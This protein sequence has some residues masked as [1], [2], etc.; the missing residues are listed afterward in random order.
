MGE[1]K[2]MYF[3]TPTFRPVGGVVKIFDYVNHAIALGYEPIVACPEPYK[4]TLPL[5]RIER[6]KGI[7][8]ENG[9]RF[10]DLDK[11]SV[12]PHDLAF[13]S[14]PTH[15]EIVEPRLSRW[16]RHEQVIFIVQNVRWANPRWIGGYAVRLLS[17]PMARIMTNDVVLDAVKPYLNPSS[18]SEVILLGNESEFFAKE[19]QSGFGEPLKV[20]YTTW[21]SG[22]G[23]EVASLLA[24]DRG[25]EFR[26]I[27]DPVGWDELRDLYQWSDVFLA[28]PLAEEGFYMPGLEAMA[29]GAVVVSPDA[30]GNRA[31]CRFGENCV[32]VEF[33]DAKGYVRALRDLK[34]AGAGEID[35]LRREGRETAGLHTLE[36]EKERFGEFMERLIGRLDRLGPG[37]RRLDARSGGRRERP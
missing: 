31:Y 5:F 22:V 2:R 24:D 21:K 36:H 33:G 29:A 32:W 35:R 16:T 34:D 26:A 20:G 10:T 4:P 27:R 19:R 9:A 1:W 28:T 18:M 13:L 3:M 6:F 11:V 37:G 15:Y 8:P 30:G 25:F 14:W 23:D 17:R 12:G 7:S